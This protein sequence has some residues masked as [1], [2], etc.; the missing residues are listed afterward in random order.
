[1]CRYLLLLIIFDLTQCRQH[2]VPG[3]DS[4]RSTLGAIGCLLQRHRWTISCMT[5]DSSQ[6][7]RAGLYS[8][9]VRDFVSTSRISPTEGNGI[10][11]RLWGPPHKYDQRSVYPSIIM[12]SKLGKK[13]IREKSHSP[14]ELLCGILM[15][16]G[17]MLLPARRWPSLSSCKAWPWPCSVCC[18]VSGSTY[19]SG[20]LSP[21]LPLRTRNAFGILM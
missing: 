20:L 18:G 7:A 21:T 6:G 14:G 15:L 8:S 3:L 2:R 17:P 12:L 13:E 5:Y 10:G 9:R 11:L 4:N 16:M 1:M 19:M